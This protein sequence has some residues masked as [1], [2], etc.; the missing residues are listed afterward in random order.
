VKKKYLII[1][2]TLLVSVDA[3]IKALC[4]SALPGRDIVLIENIISL[5]LV[6]NTGAAFS[7]FENVP[8][9]SLIVSALVF[10]GV[11]V[12]MLLGKM[13]NRA[14]LSLS[15]IAAGGLANLIDR[16][17]FGSVTDMICLEFISFPVF[18]FAD[19]CVTL[20]AFAFAVT[21]I[22]GKEDS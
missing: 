3:L 22:F 16:V 8:L 7:L 4:R 20:G 5:R 21:Y 6:F 12:F 15:F 10:A 2:I 19:I 14:R 9:A 1:P 13:S 11:I 17:I 18:N